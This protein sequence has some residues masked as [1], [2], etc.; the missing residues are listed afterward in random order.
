[1][2]NS[3]EGFDILEARELR[4]KYNANVNIAY[5][6]GGNLKVRTYERGVEDETLACGTGMAASFYRALQEGLVKEN[7]EV[8]PR[9]GD[10][11][12]LGVN[13]KTITF[14]GE[15]KRVFTTEVK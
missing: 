4:Y 7:I 11:L 15:V 3:I 5:V 8:Y 9:S 1:M 2:T 6:E 10:T 12:Y 14:K 13:E